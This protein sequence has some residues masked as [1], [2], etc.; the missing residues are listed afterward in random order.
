MR[1][2][3]TIFLCLLSVFAGGIPAQGG[4]RDSLGMF[5]FS[6][7]E[8]EWHGDSLFLRFSGLFSGRLKSSQSFRLEPFYVSGADT[9]RFP[10]LGCYS[11][12]GAR[13]RLRRNV[14]YDG[15]RDDE[16]MLTVRG[17]GDSV[18]YRA[19][20]PVSSRE[21]GEILLRYVLSDCCSSAPS[22]GDRIP[23]AARESGTPAA[24]ALLPLPVVAV[25][26]PLFEANVTFVRPEREVVKERTATLSVYLTYPLDDW[27]IYPDFGGNA[28]ELERVDRLFSPLTSDTSTYEVLSVSVTGHASVEGAWQYN[29]R[30]SGRRAE[31]MRD[32]LSGRYGVPVRQ[33][34]VQGLGEDWDGLRKAVGASDMPFREE[35]LHIIDRYDVFDGREMRLMELDHGKP[36]RYMAGNIFPSLRRMEAGICYRVRGFGAEEAGEV[37]FRRPQDLSLCEMY[38]AARSVNSDRTIGLGRSRYGL[39]YDIAVRYFPDDA[40]ANINAS[41]AALVRGDLEEAWLY[42]NR[43]KDEPKAANN[44][45]VYYWLC[46]RIPEA[47]AFFEKALKTDPLRAAF[48]LKQLSEW[49]RESCRKEALE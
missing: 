22:G 2:K 33:I 25:S 26:L 13:Y 46:N 30:L 43:V 4:C 19:G 23:V 7:G 10:A 31:S 40:V 3:V 34:S 11:R 36:Y 16:R 9:V 5:R 35:V 48:N 24:G 8:S 18:D 42:L 49:K 20:L 17:G 6:S 21:G 14:F 28:L 38:D 45:G 37:I 27:T 32:Y 44:L 15:E 39:E 29:L 41:S 12:G 47:E 1:M